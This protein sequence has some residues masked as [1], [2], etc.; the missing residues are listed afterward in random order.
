MPL[1]STEHDRDVLRLAGANPR[2]LEA[3]KVVRPGLFIF[4]RSTLSMTK[5]LN[6][7]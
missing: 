2:E 7:E 6:T 4:R 1:L 3:W 5:H